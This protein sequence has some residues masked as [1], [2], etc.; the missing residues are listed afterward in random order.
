[1]SFAIDVAMPT[2]SSGQRLLGESFERASYKRFLPLVRNDRKADTHLQQTWFTLYYKIIFEIYW[3]L[4][5]RKTLVLC[6]CIRQ[7][8]RLAFNGQ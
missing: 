5:W 1:M 2:D 8:S 7:V 6:L 4:N 3:P